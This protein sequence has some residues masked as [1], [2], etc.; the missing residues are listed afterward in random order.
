MIAFQDQGGKVFTINDRVQRENGKVVVPGDDVLTL[1]DADRD[2]CVPNQ[3][4]LDAIDLRILLMS[5]PRRRT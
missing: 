2:C 4:L 1:I 3:Y 5:S